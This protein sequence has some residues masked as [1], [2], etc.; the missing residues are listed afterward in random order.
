MRQGDNAAESERSVTA[1]QNSRA[2][3]TVHHVCHL[4]ATGLGI[5]DCVD[6]RLTN[7]WKHLECA[8]GTCLRSCMTGHARHRPIHV[9]ALVITAS[10]AMAASPSANLPHH[11]QMFIDEL[12]RVIIA[13]TSWCARH[14]APCAVEAISF[15]MLCFQ[16][17]PS[18]NCRICAA[19]LRPCSLLHQAASQL[20]CQHCLVAARFG[21]V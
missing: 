11:T 7:R 3:L 12:I 21:N 13:I 1:A 16:W 14:A 2:Q 17:Q 6:L 5:P 4:L 19:T 8:V 20:L 9:C 15:V 10:H 18:S